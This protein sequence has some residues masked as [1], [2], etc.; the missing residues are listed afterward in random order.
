MNE[1]V[2]AD[3]VREQRMVKASERWPT[4]PNV[5]PISASFQELFVIHEKLLQTGGH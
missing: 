3:D 2:A 5:I 1:H 4:S